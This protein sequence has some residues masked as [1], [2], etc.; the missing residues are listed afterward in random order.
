LKIDL[1]FNGHS[2]PFKQDLSGFYSDSCCQSHTLPD[3]INND[4]L[5]ERLLNAA[6]Q[7]WKNKELPIGSI[8]K[9]VTRAYA[10]QLIKAIEEGYG[11]SLSD[12]DFDSTDYKIL[13]GLQQQTWQFSAAKNY[14]QLRAL[15]AALL[16]DNGKIRSKQEFLKEAQKIN[17]IISKNHLTTEYNLAVQGSIQNAKWKDLQETKHL[18]PFIRFD[19]VID[20]NSSEICP[21]LDGVVLH[22]DDPRV[23]EYMPPR[24]FGCRSTWDKQAYGSSEHVEL[25]QIDISSMFKVN[26]GKRGLAFP[27]DHPYF[28]D[29]PEE[30]SESAN[31]LKEQ[32]NSEQ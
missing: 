9:E 24:H 17:D 14:H 1:N 13:E 3:L 31:K 18:F 21:P 7:I 10:T 19:S 8:D 2:T 6:L 22:I 4:E 20:E 26:L 32:K 5:T 16:D 27:P 15:G 25:P 12:V 11:K 23:D 30:V 29:L 28:I